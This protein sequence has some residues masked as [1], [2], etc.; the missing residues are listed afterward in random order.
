MPDDRFA[1][2]G[3][4]TRAG[5]RLAEL[6]DTQ[7]EPR[8][9]PPPRRQGRY[10]WVVGVAAVIAIV[11]A[12]LNSL[13][14]AGRGSHGPAAG[15]PLPHFAAPSATGPADADPNV[16][17]RAGDS[18]PNK[19]P[20]CAVRVPGALRSCDYVNKP[21]VITFI[22]PTSTC[23]R[24]VDRVDRLA[25]SFPKVNFLTVVSAPKD[26]VASLVRQHGWRQPVAVD[27]NGAVI[28]LYRVGICA[29]SVFA[30]RGGT[31]RSTKIESQHWSD[32]RL[33]SVIRATEAR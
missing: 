9:T 29:T 17:Q 27:R 26:R 15:Q 23:E 25:T 16:K 19:T 12:G 7:P 3:S 2:L 20:A 10:T 6:D 18:T 31:V 1:D 30:Y 14:H 32:A 21:L 24:F 5:D 33:A 4:G 22:V 8:R 28:S 13:P 11:V